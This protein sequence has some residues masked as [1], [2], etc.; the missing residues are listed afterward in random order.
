ML[1]RRKTRP[2]VLQALQTPCPGEMR[3]GSVDGIEADRRAFEQ[4]LNAARKQW[5]PLSAGSERVL[6]DSSFRPDVG[7]ST[8][9]H[10]HES[11]KPRLKKDP[12]PHHY[13]GQFNAPS[14]L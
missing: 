1:L 3:E 5:A 2:D 11:R 4:K 10:R 6:L 8:F 12:C 13:D 14:P 7:N 9:V